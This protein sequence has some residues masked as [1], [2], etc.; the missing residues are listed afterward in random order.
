MQTVVI[1]SHCELSLES[2]NMKIVTGE[3]EKLLPLSRVGTLMINSRQ[4]H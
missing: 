1:E 4:A 3:G 2:G